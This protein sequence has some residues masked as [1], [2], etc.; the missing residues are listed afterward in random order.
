MVVCKSN[1]KKIGVVTLGTLLLIAAVLAVDFG[2]PTSLTSW[3]TD[4]VKGEDIIIYSDHSTYSGVRSA[5]AYL[6][7]VN[8]AGTDQTFDLASLYP[9]GDGIIVT[10]LYDHSIGVCSKAVVDTCT[11]DTSKNVTGVMTCNYTTKDYF[12]SKWNALTKWSWSDSSQKGFVNKYGAKSITIKK[13][14]S[15]YFAVTFKFPEGSSGEFLFR[16]TNSFDGKEVG[17]LDPWWVATTPD[18]IKWDGSRGAKECFTMNNADTSGSTQ[19]GFCGN[20]PAAILGATTGGVGVFGESYDFEAGESDQ[21]TMADNDTFDLTATANLTI[22]A[23]GNLESDTSGHIYAKGDAATVNYYTLYYSAAADDYA[24]Q[25]NDAGDNDDAVAVEHATPPTAQWEHI[26]CKFEPTNITVYI[27]GSYST[28]VARSGGSVADATNITIGTRK[29]GAGFHRWF[30]G[31]I[32]SVLMFDYALTDSQIASVFDHNSVYNLTELLNVTTDPAITPSPAYADGQLNCSWTAVSQGY[33]TVS[34]NVTWYKDGVLDSTW[35]A[36]AISCTNN[37]AC[38]PPTAPNSTTLAYGDSYICSVKVYDAGANETVGVNSSSITIAGKGMDFVNSKNYSKSVVVGTTLQTWYNI[39]DNVTGAVIDNTYAQCWFLDDD[40]STINMAWN[41]T[42]V[43]WELSFTNAT[44]AHT[45]S[46]NLTCYDTANKVYAN[47]TATNYS[48]NVL[49][50]YNFSRVTSSTTVNVSE[51]TTFTPLPMNY[52]LFFNN[53]MTAAVSWSTAVEFDSP[54]A[55][56]TN[57]TTTTTSLAGGA[58]ATE[59]FDTNTSTDY[60][61]T[62]TNSG[63][64]G[65]TAYLGTNTHTILLNDTASGV[66][67]T[68]ST[69]TWEHTAE[70]GSAFKFYACNWANSSCNSG[71]SS[72]WI[73]HTVADAN[74][75]VSGSLYTMSGLSLSDHLLAY[76]YTSPATTTSSGGGG[77]IS[78]M[79]FVFVGLD[80]VYNLRPGQKK[81]VTFFVKGMRE[82]REVVFKSNVIWMTVDPESVVGNPVRATLTFNAPKVN[83]TFKDGLI[84]ATIGGEVITHKIDIVVSGESNFVCLLLGDEYCSIVEDF[85]GEEFYNIEGTPITGLFLV[86]G[87]FGAWFLSGKGRKT[88]KMLGLNGRKKFKKK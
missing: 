18:L 37:S 53:Q 29:N 65:T 26:C 72:G 71:A 8:V 32:D 41:A 84:T 38:Y 73:E 9:N 14:A 36:T 75:S 34:A 55:G 46:G 3:Y 81:T 51:S 39:T 11:N 12:C 62:V 83:G 76:S 4:D 82:N 56:V 7:L 66:T 87:G 1:L 16:A 69:V 21:M 80:D 19:T 78:D 28:H 27:N 50:F 33:G 74:L 44:N 22:C 43:R 17:L 42:S 67:W 24:C 30:D 15:E 10:G 31:D 23:W 45:Y 63:N 54:D 57:F 85:L 25:V 58:S 86:V 61:V 49:A 68:Y 2:N 70:S 52:S 6:K 59:I 35:N 64:L 13:G 47:I 88:R 48:S 20:N 60:N 79:D 5:M 77:G 40:S